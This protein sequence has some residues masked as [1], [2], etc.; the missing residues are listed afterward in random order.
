MEQDRTCKRCSVSRVR[1]LVD[2]FQ[3]A[4]SVQDSLALSRLKEIV[5]LAKARGY[6]DAASLLDA[7]L[8]E[9]ALRAH[10]WN[11][12]SFLTDSELERILGVKL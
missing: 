2:V 10:C 9:K 12:S 6:P 3:T 11:V 1:A 7:T 4:H 8:K 5:A